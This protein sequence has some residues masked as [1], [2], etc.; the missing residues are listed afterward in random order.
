M[1]R[2][3]T[4]AICFVLPAAASHVIPQTAPPHTSAVDALRVVSPET[5]SAANPLGIDSASRDSPGR[6]RARAAV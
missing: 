4:L 3:R 5:G 6:L 2:L 1:R